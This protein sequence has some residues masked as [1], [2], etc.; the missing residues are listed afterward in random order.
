MGKKFLFREVSCGIEIIYSNYDYK[1]DFGY[2]DSDHSFDIFQK[3][4]Q[5]R[6]QK[7]SGRP[8]CMLFMAL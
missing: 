3:E 5:G 8:G 7:F 2:S 6:R 1:Y 4:I